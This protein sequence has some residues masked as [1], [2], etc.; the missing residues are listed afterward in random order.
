VDD[1]KCVSVTRICVSVHSPQYCTDPDVTWGN[2]TGCPPVVHYWVDLQL[3]HG[4]HRYDNV[5]LHIL[6]IGAHDS[7]VATAKC[8]RVHACA[9]SMPGFL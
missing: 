4:F 2:G 1:A 7:V 8:P 9:C 6:A 3:V 5:T